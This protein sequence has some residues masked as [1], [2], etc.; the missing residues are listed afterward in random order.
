MKIYRYEVPVDDQWHTIELSGRVLSTGCRKPGVVEF[1]AISG[2]N[3]PYERSFRVVGTG[4]E[5]PVGLMS[6]DHHGSVC[7]VNPGLIWHLI[8]IGT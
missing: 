8:S 1:W 6:W 3:P 4:Q 2:E 7:D 5:I